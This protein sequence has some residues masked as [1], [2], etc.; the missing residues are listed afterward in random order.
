M[1]REDANLHCLLY[2][3]STESNQSREHLRRLLSSSDAE[4]VREVAVKVYPAWRRDAMVKS[5]RD[6]INIVSETGGVVAYL[7]DIEEPHNQIFVQELGA[8]DLHT[9]L[10]MTSKSDPNH[11]P[12]TPEET[13]EEKLRIVRALCLSVDVLHRKGVLHRDLR[14]PNVLLMNDGALK[15]C[16]FGLSK[17]MHTDANRNRLSSVLTHTAMESMGQPYE[18]ISQIREREAKVAKSSPMAGKKGPRQRN[19]DGSFVDS[20]AEPD[21]APTT[22]DTQDVPNEA[23]SRSDDVVMYSLA[24]DIFMLGSVITRVMQDYDPFGNNDEIFRKFTPDI[25]LPEFPGKPM[26]EHLLS[27][28]LDHDCTKRPSITEVL[29]HPFFHSWWK[30]KKIIERLDLVLFQERDTV[31]LNEKFIA[32]Q[33]L[34][35]PLE[36]DFKELSSD[37]KNFAWRARKYNS[38]PPIVREAFKVHQKFDVLKMDNGQPHPL[39]NV[40]LAIRF[41]RNFVTHILAQDESVLEGFKI[42]IPSEHMP[43]YPGDFLIAND[44]VMGIFTSIWEQHRLKVNQIT[45]RIKS[46]FERHKRAKKDLEDEK[47]ELAF[48]TGSDD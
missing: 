41:C 18:V 2:R 6:L 4:Q 21:A 44:A 29:D 20:V 28:M 43:S 10:N 45:Q 47:L 7:D 12:L 27:T 31:K 33:R 26:L 8:I 32:V 39:P 13:L 36:N 22:D 16:D 23:D 9:Y 37:D 48:L 5:E 46:E 25:Q 3:E 24:N 11:Q 30:R 34:I 38:L 42:G 35:E 40:Q 15:I 14:T 1:V 19:K 17:K